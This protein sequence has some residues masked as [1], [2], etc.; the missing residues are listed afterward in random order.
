MWRDPPQYWEQIVYPAYVR[1]HQHLF[2]NGDV[3]NGELN[4]QIPDLVMLDGLKENL[5]QTLSRAM[6]RIL[7]VSKGEEFYTV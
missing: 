6:E 3:E 2:T 5:S 4:G 1:A 7:E